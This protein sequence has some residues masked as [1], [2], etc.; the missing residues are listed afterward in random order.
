MLSLYQNRAHLDEELKKQYNVGVIDEKNTEAMKKL[1]AGWT[2]LEQTA[3][4]LRIQIVT[5]LVQPLHEGLVYLEQ[6]LKRLKDWMADPENKT[7]VNPQWW[8]KRADEWNSPPP[9]WWPDWMKEWYRGRVQQLYGNNANTGPAPTSP[10]TPPAPAPSGAR[11]APAWGPSWLGPYRMVPAP[12]AAPVPAPTPAPSVAPTPAPIPTPAPSAA[13]V[14]A[15][16]PAPP[17]APAPITTP[18][19]VPAPI[20]TPAPDRPSVLMPMPA[21]P[22]SALAAPA[23]SPTIQDL[24]RMRSEQR[25]R[26]N[27]GPLTAPG[28]Q[29]SI[30]PGLLMMPQTAALFSRSNFASAPSRSINTNSNVTIGA[31]TFNSTTTDGSMLG[32]APAG[33]SRTLHIGAYAVEANSSLV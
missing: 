1:H 21:P 9:D 30:D 27:Y 6:V 22:T 28:P 16:T 13:P 4:N 8:S 11:V 15:P 24:N 20:P 33:S 10:S 25:R 3:E 31:M 2:N 7:W 5:N 12:P 14:P 26:G 18:A 19:P 32:H 23:T 29:S 17:A